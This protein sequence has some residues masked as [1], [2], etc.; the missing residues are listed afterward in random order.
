MKAKIISLKELL[1]TFV[2]CALKFQSKLD[3][4]KY[5]SMKVAKATQKATKEAQKLSYPNYVIYFKATKDLVKIF[6]LDANL[7]LDYITSDL[8]IDDL[9]KAH[10]SDA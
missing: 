5:L 6:T 7:C 3:E 9:K 8:N 4:F 10:D 2:T 1:Q